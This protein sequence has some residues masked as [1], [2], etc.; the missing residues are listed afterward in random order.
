MRRHSREGARAL[1]CVFEQSGGSD[2]VRSREAASHETLLIS[3]G[4]RQSLAQHLL[5]I[6]AR[7]GEAA[8]PPSLLLLLLL[9]LLQVLVGGEGVLLV[10]DL[11]GGRN[12]IGM[13]PRELHVLRQH[14]AGT[15]PP[16]APDHLDH[17]QGHQHHQRHSAQHATG[18]DHRLGPARGGLTM[19]ALAAVA[20]AMMPLVVVLLVFPLLGGWRRAVLM[21]AVCA[22]LMRR[23]WSLVLVAVTAVLRRRRWSLVLV[24]VTAV[25]RGRR[26]SLVLVAVTA[27][28]RRRRRRRRALGVSTQSGAAADSLA[29]QESRAGRLE[30]AAL[31]D[32]GSCSGVHLRFTL[33]LRGRGG[34]RRRRRAAVRGPPLAEAPPLLLIV[35][36]VVVVGRRR[37]ARRLAVVGQVAGRRRAVVGQLAVLGDL[38][39]GRAGWRT[40]RLGTAL[41]G[42]RRR[43][44]GAV[45]TTS[46]VVLL[47]LCQGSLLGGLDLCRRFLGKG[48]AGQC[49]HDKERNKQSDKADT[50]PSFSLSQL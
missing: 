50:H 7:W 1:R 5:V 38:F 40:P 18:N 45:A 44:V 48:G 28:L 36:L 15:L 43:T 25:L 9:L 20:V 33:A 26:W 49:Q 19:R 13:P 30:T 34:G 24:A 11:H 17:H 39:V 47:S 10:H 14:G 37:G 42:G 6:E 8:D 22:V 27:V 29:G 3:G 16:A 41:L 46:R 31:C 21:V 23:R 4:G 2:G 35:V 12:A 32:D